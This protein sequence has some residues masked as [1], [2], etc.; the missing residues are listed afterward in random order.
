MSALQPQPGEIMNIAQ[1]PHGINL[2]VETERIVYIGRF[3][4]T[5]GFEVRMHDAAMHMLSSGE[6]PEDYIRNTAKYGVPVEH[7]D[8][9]FEAATIR[10][11]R[12]LGDVPKE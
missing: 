2:V 4:R 9:V 7:K 8:L 11:V 12:R 10:R 6:N 1:A 3:D 5:N